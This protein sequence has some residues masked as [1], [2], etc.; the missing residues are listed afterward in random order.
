ME[1]I[2]NTHTHTHT[3]THTQDSDTLPCV[4]VWIPNKTSCDF[5]LF[6]SPVENINSTHTPCAPTLRSRNISTIIHIDLHPSVPTISLGDIWNLP[7]RQEIRLMKLFFPDLSNEE[8]TQRL[9]HTHSRLLAGPSCVVEVNLRQYWVASLRDGS[10]GVVCLNPNKDDQRAYLSWKKG[11][12][13]W[14]TSLS[15]RTKEFCENDTS[16]N[17]V[18]KPINFDRSMECRRV[19]SDEFLN[20]FHELL[21]ERPFFTVTRISL[22][23]DITQHTHTHLTIIQILF[24]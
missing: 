24:F 9:R 19:W 11:R 10:V 5:L 3:H 1:Y 20:T 16:A 13:A 8:R 7:E 23:R 15:A 6:S 17:G 4:I 21:V 22:P 14:E 18:L 2:I 12:C